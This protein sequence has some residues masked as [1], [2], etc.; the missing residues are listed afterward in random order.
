MNCGGASSAADK[1]ALFHDLCVEKS[2]FR[3]ACQLSALIGQDFLCSTRH[4]D[5]S[6]LS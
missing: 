4:L 3:R 2:K 6:L 5:T 1:F